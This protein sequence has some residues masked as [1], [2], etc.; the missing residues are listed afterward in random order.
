MGTHAVT[1]RGARHAAPPEEIAPTSNK[2][3]L[4]AVLKTVGGNLAS[5]VIGIAT[6]PIL[7]YSLGVTGRGEFAA[8]TSPTLL[9]TLAGTLGLPEAAT[10]FV[11]S[12]RL[13]VRP[14]L[15]R[16]VRL[17]VFLGALLAAVLFLIAPLITSGS[18]EVTRLIFLGGCS[19]PLALAVGA[20]RGVAAGVGR[21]GLVNS[22]QL[23]SNGLRLLL[24]VIAASTSSLTLPV[25][26]AV[27]LSCPVL[28]GLVYL[29]FWRQLRNE[30]RRQRAKGGRG[31]S[32]L[33]VRYG[34]YTWVGGL[35][36]VILSRLDQV[37]IAPLAGARE[38]G[39]YAA[40]VAIGELPY[41]VSAATD[42]VMLSKDAAEA[43]DGRAELAGR[44]TFLVTALVAGV[45]A[46]AAPL[47]V[48]LAFGEAFKPATPMLQLLLLAAVLNTPGS[49]AGAVLM[50]RGRPGVR[51]IS[52]TAACV[53]NVALLPVLVPWAGGVGAA[54]ASVI[55]YGLFSVCNLWLAARLIGLSP[56]GMMLPRGSD[57]AKLRLTLQRV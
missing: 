28:G 25:A 23:L 43:N 32:A 2:S 31:S 45:L 30:I 37:L 15:E 34:A 4:R 17:S 20:L 38:L 14:T 27:Y 16:V 26:V 56:W 44:L 52:L 24:V 19:L 36:G 57:L 53:I 6:A 33:L 9:L 22:E 46:L 42:A 35:S 47:L 8:A 41:V 10:Y 12:K 3:F 11:A 49:T 51:S 54:W 7:A 1:R 50:A 55:S 18:H 40:A 39:F 5:P 21:W 13:L 29:P 48:R